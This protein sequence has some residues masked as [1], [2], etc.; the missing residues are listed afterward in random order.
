MQLDHLAGPWVAKGLRVVESGDERAVVA[1]CYGPEQE[2]RDAEDAQGAERARL[3]A[4]APELLAALRLALD[5]LEGSFC[6]GGSS[7]ADYSLKLHRIEAARAAIA[8]ATT[9]EGGRDAA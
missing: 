1:L 6:L 3:V 8:K 4:A 5:G 2:D 9:T 7:V